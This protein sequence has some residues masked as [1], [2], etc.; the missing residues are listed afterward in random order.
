MT[1]MPRGGMRSENDIGVAGAQQ[2]DPIMAASLAAT[3][4]NESKHGK[5]AGSRKR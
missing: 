1:R 5:Q 3:A 4:R 2:H